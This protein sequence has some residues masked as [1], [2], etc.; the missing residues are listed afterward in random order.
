MYVHPDL[1]HTQAMLHYWNGNICSLYYIQCMKFSQQ[2]CMLIIQP[3]AIKFEILYSHSHVH[4][5][6]PYAYSGIWMPVTYMYIIGYIQSPFTFSTESFVTIIL[7]C[8]DVPRCGYIQCQHLII[9]R[10]ETACP[11]IWLTTLLF[12]GLDKYVKYHL[13]VKRTVT[14]HSGVQ[15]ATQV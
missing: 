13:P 5:Y 15:L 10:L 11:V 4:A 1:S 9:N 8:G 2:N 7:M 14:S 12:K 3:Y 6:I